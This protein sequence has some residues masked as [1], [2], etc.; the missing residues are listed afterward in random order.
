MNA[1]GVMQ[2]FAKRACRHIAMQPYV[3]IDCAPIAV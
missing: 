3:V 1:M 2:I